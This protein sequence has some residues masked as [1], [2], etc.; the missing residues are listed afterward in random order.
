MFITTIIIAMNY[1]YDY[2]YYY[3]YYC[4]DYY[5]CYYYLLDFLEEGF[6]S[7]DPGMSPHREG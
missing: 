3:Q 2:N 6:C 7:V 4:C 1:N 5:Y